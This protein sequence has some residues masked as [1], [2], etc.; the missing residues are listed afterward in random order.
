MNFDNIPLR[1]LIAALFL[2]GCA[3]VGAVN[4]ARAP[5][6]GHQQVVGAYRA[7]GGLFPVE[8]AFA[9]NGKYIERVGQ[10]ERVGT[11][12]RIENRLTWTSDGQKREAV[13]VSSDEEALEIIMLEPRGASGLQKV[14]MPRLR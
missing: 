12:D 1:V 10:E 3:R 13:V 14:R 2:S 6:D 9:A 5:Q 7:A 11:W 4:N 8:F